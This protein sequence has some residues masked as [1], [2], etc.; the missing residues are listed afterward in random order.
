MKHRFLDHVPVAKMLDH[1]PLEQWQRDSRVP[2][3]LRVDDHDR[4]A[5]AYAETGRFTALHAPRA[6][7]KPLALKEASQFCIQ[8]APA[9]IGS[10]EATDAH[11]DVTRVGIHERRWRRSNRGHAESSEK[12]MAV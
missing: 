8:R 9:A 1:N 11:Q 5:G 6:E 4:A 2:H 10:A 3:A 12:V 7:E